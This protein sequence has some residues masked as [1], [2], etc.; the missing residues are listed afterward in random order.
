MSGSFDD[1][2]LEIFAAETEGFLNTLEEIL[3]NAEKGGDIRESTPEIFRI[4]HTIKSSSAMM[5]LDNISKLAHKVEDLFSYIREKQPKVVDDKRLVD[6]VLDSVDFIKNNMTG[7][8][9]E[10]PAEKIKYIG[11]YLAEMQ[12]ANE[13]GSPVPKPV[14]APV[15]TEEASIKK[16][17][18]ASKVY[19][20]TVKFKPETI[21]LG[22]RAFEIQNKLKQISEDFF[23]IP[24]D[25]STD[26]ETIKA[27]GL[28]LIL[29]TAEPKESVFEI[30]KK[31]PF[32]SDITD[33]DIE[34]P[35]IKSKEKVDEP[36]AEPEVKIISQPVEKEIN[37]PPKGEA[38]KEAAVFANVEIGKLNELVDIA[39]ELIIAQMEIKSCILKNDYKNAEASVEKLKKLLLTLQ[40]TALS[41]R[42]VTIRET[43]MKM[44]RIVRDMCRK[45]G[46]KI[47]FIMEGIDTEVDRSIIENLSSPLMHIIRN[48]VDHGIETP[49]ERKITG[50]NEEGTVKLVAYT[51]NRNVIIYVEDDGKGINTEKVLA[52]AIKQN[53]ITQEKAKSM[54]KE[55]INA[56]IFIPGFSTNQ[57]VTE[58]SGRGVGM[59]VVNESIKK[60]N[61]RIII[62]SEKGTGSKFMLKIPLTLAII[63]AALLKVNDNI[64]ACPV[65]AMGEIFYVSSNENISCVNG[66][67]VVFHDEECYK[68][69]NLFDFYSI[70][71]KPEYN[72]GVFIVTKTEDKKYVLFANEVIERQDIVV[73]SVPPILKS[74]NEISGYT[75][76]GDGGISLILD[77][78]E[79]INYRKK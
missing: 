77:T 60:M 32:V 40:E 73:K 54:T 19:N 57:L 56:L 4:M 39:G 1:S 43:F 17:D 66:D 61:G 44:N 52:K 2:L 33:L 16:N 78:D 68:I 14:E 63:D 31:S 58:Y 10:D 48:S 47:N 59:D 79:M 12:A 55:E 74:I 26:E 11:E 8:V 30:V 15:K 72:E 50:K 53:I 46:K 3:L 36:V 65:G 24:E 49:E 28:T 51:E 27:N 9:N 41:T 22:L 29:K 45:Q 38:K 64:C 37:L 69:I 25:T 13:I 62:Q 18:G 71:N 6:I 5:S 35:E 20:F 70:D 7:N 42:M 76:L 21:M 34:E 23:S 67:N 75:I